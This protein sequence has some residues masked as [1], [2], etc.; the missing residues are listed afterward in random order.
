MQQDFH[1]YATYCAAYL[2]GFS[3]DECL[4]I[5]YSAEF[6]D[7]CSKTLLVSIGAPTIAA[8]T[9]LQ[10]EMMDS[11]TD[12]LGLQEITRIWSSFHFLPYD[13]YATKKWRPKRYMNKYRLICKPN[14]DLLKKTV[15]LADGKSLQHFGIA[16]HVLADTW[17]HSYFAG[18]PSLVIN[19]TENEFYELLSDESGNISEKKIRFKHNPSSSDDLENNIFN[20]CIYQGNESSIMNLGHGRAGHLP[21]Y[22]FI[23]Y[24]Y[25]PAW[26]DYKETIKDN[27]SD[28]YNAFCQMVYALKYLKD[29]EGDF[30][31]SKYDYETVAPYE[32][33]I[34][35]ILS[36]RQ[37][38]ASKDWK[39]FGEELS[40]EKIKDFKREK[41]N[42]EYAYAHKI[43]KED[44]F[45]GKFIEAAISQKSMVTNEIFLSK[46]YLAGLSK[47]VISK[48]G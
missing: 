44:T 30:E 40:G 22:S 46:N 26:D 38:I 45:L 20:N 5:C 42:D 25:I 43:H 35:E 34:K 32:D 19:N 37:L 36:K 23:K 13:L 10:L 14:G 11:R 7:H 21:D 3:H 27:P 12:I 4:D 6:V 8:T 48:I 39:N 33:R 1:Y 9:Q 17:A 47:S 18:T 29:G 2:A 24:R 31:L 28:Y 15:E 16:M 41:Y